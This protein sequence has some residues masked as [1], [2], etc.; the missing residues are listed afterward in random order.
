MLTLIHSSN[1]TFV[2]LLFYYARS[3]AAYSRA[4]VSLELVLG[5][6]GGDRDLREVQGSCLIF[7]SLIH[8]LNFTCRD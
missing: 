6:E 2:D 8:F 4:N 1:L 7:A 3:G 5:I